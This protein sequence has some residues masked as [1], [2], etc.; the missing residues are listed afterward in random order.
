MPTFG[1]L[2]TWY[3]ERHLKGK[4]SYRRYRPV[5]DRIL[6]PAGFASQPASTLSR[7][8]VL[9]ISQRWQDS[10]AQCQKI[11]G[12]VRQTYNWAANTIHSRRGEP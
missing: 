5:F 12:L 1:T 10:L 8:E 6:V 11:V 3:L 9:A 2:C 4:P 7:Y